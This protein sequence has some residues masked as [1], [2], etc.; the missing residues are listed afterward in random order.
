MHTR[1]PASPNPDWHNPGASSPAVALLGPRQ[2]GPSWDGLVM[3]TPLRG[4]PEYA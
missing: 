2:A 3:E 4:G 1:S